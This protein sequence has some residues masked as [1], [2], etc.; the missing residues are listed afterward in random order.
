MQHYQGAYKPCYKLY[1]EVCPVGQ[2][3]LL[4]PLR[5]TTIN[6][7]TG[8]YSYLT[9]QRKNPITTINPEAKSASSRNETQKPSLLLTQTV[10]QCPL[11][12]DTHEKRRERN[13]RALIS[14]LPPFP[15][16]EEKSFG[17]K[18]ART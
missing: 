5:V 17:R 6:H 15:P 18:G 2:M 16:S 3:S 10:F 7:I 13:F 12:S 11:L 1:N 9:P 4:L 14:F 8:H